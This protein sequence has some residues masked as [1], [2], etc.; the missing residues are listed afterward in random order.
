MSVFI[1]TN[2]T[3]TKYKVRIILD[4]KLPLKCYKLINA[5]MQIKTV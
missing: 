5:L 4:T 2:I 1:D 3:S